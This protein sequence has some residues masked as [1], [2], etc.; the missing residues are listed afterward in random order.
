MD[1]ARLID[2]TLLKPAA[3]TTDIKNL[4]KEAMDHSFFAVC[5]PPCYVSCARQELQGTN[6]KIATVIGFPLGYSVAKQAEI[7]IAVKDG[8]DELDI[9]H[10]I[11]AFK[12]GDYSYCEQEMKQCIELAHR[13]NKKIKI[14]LE[15]GLLADEEIIRAC[16]LYAPYNPDFL[17]TS[18]GFTET[19]ATVA[20]V[21]LLRKNLPAHIA[22]KASGGIRNFAFAKELVEAGATRLG[23][24]AGIQILEQS[25]L[26]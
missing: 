5:V 11:A 13:N 23:C 9:V 25:K 3:T 6:V 19:G 1:I 26:S 4:C 10:N 16:E 22:I 17:K 8:T 24:S 21:K 18:T 7:E 20:A 15:T 14:I 12:T 2:H